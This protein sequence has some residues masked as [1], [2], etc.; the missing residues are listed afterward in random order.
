MVIDMNE[1]EIQKCGKINVH[2]SLIFSC[3]VTNNISQN[4]ALI[5]GSWFIILPLVIIT[6]VM[7]VRNKCKLFLSLICI[8]IYIRS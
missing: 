7:Y 6:A 5:P 8:Y 4:C 3:G 2:V 1:V